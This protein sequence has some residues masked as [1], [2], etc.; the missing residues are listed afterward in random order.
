MDALT[1]YQI[2]V[3]TDLC[4]KTPWT[5]EDAYPYLLSLLQEVGKQT[6]ALVCASDLIAVAA[7]RAAATCG[8]R[9]PDDI[10][11]TGFD[12]LPMVRDLDPPLTTVAAPKELLGR[13]AVRKLIERIQN[14]MLPPITQ[15]L[16]TMV[17][18]RSSCG[19]L[20][21]KKGLP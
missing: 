1:H 12:D 3:T 7:L 9:V 18:V 6:D 10:A 14:P 5:T 8:M 21:E 20:L 16:P 17:V 19:A 15:V 4:V 13:F 11:V 2:P